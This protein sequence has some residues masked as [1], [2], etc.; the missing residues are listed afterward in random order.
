MSPNP[1]NLYGL[2][3]LMSPNRIIFIGFGD[4]TQGREFRQIEDVGRFSKSIPPNVCQRRL[5][6]FQ[7]CLEIII[8]VC[9][10]PDFPRGVPREDPDGMFPSK[11]EGLGPVPARI[12]GVYMFSVC[13]V[14]L[15]GQTMPFSLDCG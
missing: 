14:S 7:L 1:I 4:I 5:V 3:P 2:G 12:W 8:C 6:I 9:S 11:I 10:W 13:N 15:S